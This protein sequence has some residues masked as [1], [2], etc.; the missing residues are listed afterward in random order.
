MSTREKRDCSVVNS[1]RDIYQSL[2]RCLLETFHQINS[3]FFPCKMETITIIS[4]SWSHDITLNLKVKYNLEIV[5]VFCE[6]NLPKV[7][8]NRLSY[9]VIWHS[10]NNAI[11]SLFWNSINS[12]KLACVMETIKACI[13]VIFYY[14]RK[15]IV[16]L[17]RG[18][19]VD[20]M[21]TVDTLVTP[22]PQALV[23]LAL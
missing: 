9:L 10:G 16:R 21:Y 6:N 22:K 1:F 8:S 2:I 11:I 4:V 12:C 14:F 7:I 20:G 17:S 19:V 15:R 23:W 18:W 13:S 3:L 5:A